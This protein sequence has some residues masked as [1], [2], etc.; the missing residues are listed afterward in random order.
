[1]QHSYLVHI[2]VGSNTFRWHQRWPA[3]DLVFG[4]WQPSIGTCYF[5][6]LYYFESKLKCL[7]NCLCRNLTNCKFL[8]EHSYKSTFISN[9]T[10][11]KSIFSPEDVIKL[12]LIAQMLGVNNVWIT[13]GK[14]CCLVY[15]ECQISL[16]RP[17]QT[18]VNPVHLL[19][20][21]ICLSET[22]WLAPRSQGGLCFL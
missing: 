10:W 4:L 20:T 7:R 6:N 16:W 21:T 17:P 9:C 13:H 8:T 15:S 18:Q 19:S 11:T 1:M 22:G 3:Y 5:K 12:K 2:L 14:L